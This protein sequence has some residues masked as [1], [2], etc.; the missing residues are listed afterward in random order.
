[1]P[2]KP[3]HSA[4]GAL[5]NLI[6]PDTHHHTPTSPQAARRSSLHWTRAAAVPPRSHHLARCH[7]ARLARLAAERIEGSEREEE[8]E[9]Y[10]DKERRVN[11]EK[12]EELRR[13][14]NRKGEKGKKLENK[15]EMNYS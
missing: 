14:K 13:K 7:S 12:G 2:P 4:S 11:R 6:A 8:I 10:I 5:V 9:S 1:M 15:K 3:L